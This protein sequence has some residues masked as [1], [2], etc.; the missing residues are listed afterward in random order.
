MNEPLTTLGIFAPS[1]WV[2]KDDILEA[3]KFAEGHHFGTFIHPQTFLRHNQSA[4]TS[5]EKLQ[6]FYDL[7][8]NPEIDVIWAAGGGNRCLHWI[9]D[10]DFGQLKQN[11][12]KPV[13]GYSDVTAL[14]NTLYAHGGYTGFHGPTF[15][16]LHK[17]AQAEQCLSLLSGTQSNY[18]FTK[19]KTIKEGTAEGPMIG[20]NLS[21][22]QYLP[23]TLPGEFWD[24]AIVFLE[25][26]N[27]ELSRI[28]RMLIH[29]RRCGVFE[30]AAGIIFG[31]FGDLSDT[32]RPFG[33]TIEEILREH[34]NGCNGPV[35][36]NAPF[37]HGKDLYTF[38]VGQR[39]VLSLAEKT[40]TLK[41][42]NK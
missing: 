27:E 24:G 39:A 32:G 13:I 31:D 3:Q 30:K 10:I 40:K 29:L 14:L 22:F 15:N 38:P 8:E 26:C 25:D 11:D 20:G 4:G 17:A 23:H 35:L 16:R 12:D 19:A 34:T 21:V 7:W 2:E 37:G 18:D 1:S 9:D 5:A 28:D 42:L 36:M 6:A 33:F 41:L